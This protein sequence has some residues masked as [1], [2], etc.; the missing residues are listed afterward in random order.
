MFVRRLEKLADHLET[1]ARQPKPERVFDLASWFG[2]D[3]YTCGTRA[4]AVGEACFIPEFKKAGLRLTE[5]TPFIVPT[6]KD[7]DNWDAVCAFFGIKLP[8]A[9]RLFNMYSY[10]DEARNDSERVAYRIRNTVKRYRARRR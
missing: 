3:P 8:T 2:R 4:C 6:Y 7:S 9:I 1:V 10:P 5:D